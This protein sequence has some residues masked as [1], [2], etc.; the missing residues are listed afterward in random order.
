MNEKDK[1]TKCLQEKTDKKKKI[2]Q[3]FDKLV[4]QNGNA[5]KRLSKE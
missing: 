1:Q 5:L 2:R 3:S 4:K